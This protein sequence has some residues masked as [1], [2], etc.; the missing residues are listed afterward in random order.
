MLGTLD[1]LVKWSYTP[2]GWYNNEQNGLKFIL[3]D[4]QSVFSAKES[5]FDF[6]YMPH[7][8]P[9]SPLSWTLT[10]SPLLLHPLHETSHTI[11]GR[12]DTPVCRD[13]LDQFFAPQRS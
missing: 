7:R 3:S 12:C 5:S 6:R 11:P 9:I 1:F 4:P 13:F 2:T 8:A 10:N